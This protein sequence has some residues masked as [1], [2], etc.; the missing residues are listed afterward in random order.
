[1]PLYTPEQRERA[2]RNINLPPNKYFDEFGFIRDTQPNVDNTALATAKTSDTMSPLETFIGSGL[3]SVLPS[4]GG[5]GA[6]MATGAAG[7]SVWP[8]LGTFLGALGGAILGGGAISYGQDKLANY[9]A[10]ETMKRLR[11]GQAENPYAAGIGAFA[12]SLPTF[13]PTLKP[14]QFL[15][16]TAK[17]KIMSMGHKVDTG[18]VVEAL[19]DVGLGAGVEAGMSVATDI[20]QDR[21]VSLPRA[22]L[23][24][25]LGAVVSQP[26]KLAT[27]LTGAT[28]FEAPLD[29]AEYIRSGLG[30]GPAPAR[31]KLLQAPT[32]DSLSVAGEASR[33]QP[34]SE[35]KTAHGDKGLTTAYVN[36]INDFLESYRN[37]HLSTIDLQGES[38]G[39]YTPGTREMYA[40]PKYANFQTP[41]HE[42]MHMMLDDLVTS[43]AK[44]DRK[45]V[46]LLFKTVEDSKEFNEWSN[47]PFLKDGRTPSDYYKGKNYDGRSALVE[48]FIAERGGWNVAMEILKTANKKSWF[49]VVKHLKKKWTTG[50]DSEDYNWALAQRFLYDRAYPTDKLFTTLPKGRQQPLDDEDDWSESNYENFG[51][52]QQLARE[53]A[54]KEKAAKEAGQAAGRQVQEVQGGTTQ[55]QKTAKVAPLGAGSK[56]I[57]DSPLYREMAAKVKRRADGEEL[58]RLRTQLTEGEGAKRLRAISYVRP[59]DLADLKMAASKVR[60]KS[61][62][63]EELMAV[64]I[65]EPDTEKLRTLI[66]NVL[67]DIIMDARGTK[68]RAARAKKVVDTFYG[69]GVFDA[70]EGSSRVHRGESLA[71]PLEE[72][73]NLFSSDSQVRAKEI[74][75]IFDKELNDTNSFIPS[76]R[77][78]IYAASK[79]T[80]NKV[81]ELLNNKYEGSDEFLYRLHRGLFDSVKLIKELTNDSFFLEA[82][83]L[84][85]LFNQLAMS[86]RFTP[87]ELLSM[88]KKANA[89]SEK[90]YGP[91]ISAFPN[92]IPFEARFRE[93]P[94]NLV[95]LNADIIWRITK[96]EKP[97]DI[98]IDRIMFEAE[99]TT[100][101]TAKYKELYLRYSNSSPKKAIDDLSVAIPYL[102][103]E[104]FHAAVSKYQWP[105]TANSIH[106]A[107]TLTKEQLD[108]PFIFGGPN[109]TRIEV[110]LHK[111]A[112]EMSLEQWSELGTETKFPS[113]KEL[114]EVAKK[115]Y[116]DSLTRDTNPFPP[117]PKITNLTRGIRQIR[118]AFDVKEMK[119]KYNNCIVG[120]IPKALKGDTFL[121]ET[122]SAVAEIR[123]DGGLVQHLGD[124]NRAPSD[125]DKEAMLRFAEANPDL[126][127]A[128]TAW[129]IT[130]RDYEDTILGERARNKGIRPEQPI[131]NQQ[132]TREVRE[133]L[134]EEEANAY[135]A[136][137]NEARLRD[138]DEISLRNIAEIESDLADRLVIAAATEQDP[139]FALRQS[140]GGG[141]AVFQKDDNKTIEARRWKRREQPVEDRQFFTTELERELRKNPK[142]PFG[143]QLRKDGTIRADQLASVLRMKLPR[144]EQE[145][146][147]DMFKWL[148]DKG[149]ELVDPLIL[150]AKD[151][152][153]MEHS[154][155][156]DITTDTIDSS[157]LNK[158]KGIFDRVTSN[159]QQFQHLMDNEGLSVRVST[160]HEGFPFAIYGGSVNVRPGFA[161][162]PLFAG[163]HGPRNIN[164]IDEWKVTFKSDPSEMLDEKQIDL[165]EA[166]IKNKQG[167]VDLMSMFDDDA[168]GLQTRDNVRWDNI[169]PRKVDTLPDYTELSVQHNQPGE[170]LQGDTIDTHYFPTNTMTHVRGYMHTDEGTGEKTFVI[171]EAQSDWDASIRDTNERRKRELPDLEHDL[172][173]YEGILRDLESIVEV[174]PSLEHSDSYAGFDKYG[175]EIVAFRASKESVQ[176]KIAYK[177]RI[178]KSDVANQKIAVDNAREG[179]NKPFLE[180]WQA[181]A[182]K[183]AIRHAVKEGADRI[184]IT[185]APTSMITQ[186]HI[187]YP[188]TKKF[189]SQKL[190]ESY[191]NDPYR[192]G[193]KL[194]VYQDF[195]TKDWYVRSEP[196]R[197]SSAKVGRAYKFRVERE[198]G[199]RV[200]YE[201]KLPSI[202]KKLVGD[203]G[204]LR[205]YGDTDAI[206]EDAI[207]LAKLGAEDFSLRARSYKLSDEVKSK[208]LNEQ[209]QMFSDRFQPLDTTLPEPTAK[210]WKI[211][212]DSFLES[213][214]KKVSKLG[215]SGSY[216]ADKMNRYYAK[217]GFYEGD[218]AN[219][220]AMFFDGYVPP[221]GSEDK[222]VRFLHDIRHKGKSKVNLTD[223][224]AH[225]VM[226]WKE[227]LK[228][229][230]DKH[231]AIGMLIKEGP[232]AFREMVQD[233]NYSPDM[234]DPEVVYY[235]T[236]NRASSD[237]RAR[238]LK[239]DFIDWALQ[240]SD[241]NDKEALEYYN[242]YMD[243]VSGVRDLA[244]NNDRAYFG[245]LRRAKSIGLPY[246][247]VEKNPIRL[248][249]RYGRRTAHDFAFFEELQNDPTARWVSGLV[250]QEGNRPSELPI[251]SIAENPEVQS[252]MQG[253]ILGDSPYRGAD[254]LT[255]ARIASAA[256]VVS[257]VIMGAGTGA[258]DIFTLPGTMAPYLQNFGDLKAVLKGARRTFKVREKALR[259]G[260]TQLDYDAFQFGDLEYAAPDRIVRNLSKASKFF[261]KYQGR[262]LLENV[263]RQLTYAIGEEIAATKIAQAKA[264]DKKA[265]KWLETFTKS[266]DDLTA[267]DTVSRIAKEFT[268]RVQ[269]AYDARNLPGIAL[270]GEIAPFLN[271]ARWSIEKYNVVK[272]DVFKPM[273]E[274]DFKPLLM[275]TLGSM[276]SA[277]AIEKLNELLSNKRGHDATLKEVWKSPDASLD[278]YIYK[279]IALGQLGAFAG[280]A[281]DATK[282]ATAT[283]TGRTSYNNPLSFPLYTFV[284]ETL[285]D[286][287]SDATEAIKEGEDPVNTLLNMTHAIAKGSLQNYRYVSSW[288]DH[289]E[290]KRKEKFRDLAVWKQL[291][292]ETDAMKEVRV[293]RFLKQ[294][295]RKFKQSDDLG[296]S[297][298]MLEGLI[299][300]AFERAKG[301]PFK[302]KQELAGLKANS[303]QTMPSPK[304]MP[305]S[306]AKY[307][308]HLRETQGEEAAN[309][310][311]QDWM[312]Q[313]AKNRVKSGMVP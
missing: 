125:M 218:F 288:Y 191:A 9:I 153:K 193:Q 311:L 53:R 156:R 296:E 312:L 222:I 144:A 24:G 19:A 179:I 211:A 67:P 112:S 257:N 6:G 304:T 91:S 271:L 48:E 192:K 298:S 210:G 154:L 134:G 166:Y 111:A 132:F 297:T 89:L 189:S 212:P 100:D 97:F 169:L 149:Q 79:R 116:Q 194:D 246:S 148:E 252:A 117:N 20:A 36:K 282:L 7:G 93:V 184:A 10:P 34:I 107:K 242:N 128:D 270:E 150:T 127:L 18:K 185:D 221:K 119:R 262:Q 204:E 275:Y 283:V 206:G 167:Q 49:D 72:N 182:L 186:G 99:D 215:E 187:G 173:I 164:N 236:H 70:L 162:A 293:N 292:D 143:L 142:R 305:N 260:S 31:T 82:P 289:K 286:N 1:M 158:E 231:K 254:Q 203:K 209:T 52:K 58:L 140:V 261:R 290:T 13:R 301:D 61:L 313:N 161:R 73:D 213:R 23:M 108:K 228:E 277:V 285:A 68:A 181:T 287:L 113:I 276:L 25:T 129:H 256:R 26:T 22:A 237:P 207:T 195:T 180:N 294:D 133:K 202:M 83:T 54:A 268:D 138:Y 131:E 273:T 74:K 90:E 199:H 177:L 244:G 265:K 229:I 303:Y 223:Q 60:H 122:A 109:N 165:I 5:L 171:L 175:N 37:A 225:I 163:I 69:K 12:G 55:A 235:M 308:L 110:P 102:F 56:S 243:A 75:R 197:E 183:A 123:P 101:T 146:L 65:W 2:A 310:R 64:P 62:A 284:T 280:I 33:G 259:S 198:M 41:L 230:G 174:K 124:W 157:L 295:E 115:A 17:R 8:G 51:L 249:Y 178:A 205:T 118:N 135:H 39:A 87:Y 44:V 188:L 94:P 103:E 300:K 27:K 306:F 216:L 43:D 302:F 176:N 201:T 239:D 233:P 106:L 196:T 46:D 45:L 227:H 126:Y 3:E 159:L 121:Y 145:V 38:R 80:L 47:S 279:I 267:P 190:A 291:N 86:G 28:P 136:A 274:G 57:Q 59:R 266:V 168:Q 245:A 77:D 78:S 130:R 264:G 105:Y 141:K 35:L 220:A 160:T 29:S 219:T 151:D 98:V 50:L 307:L 137:F 172:K 85:Q 250:D 30:V 114:R 281:S 200:N 309:A 15:S 120:F 139:F 104:H 214:V 232:K 240:K 272:E 4:L 269:G 217:R 251:D 96:G 81:S 248:F 170:R 16:E 208:F 76:D 42:G 88:Q 278:D 238:K 66:G 255:H 40:D 147:G 253:I 241:M 11:E 32:E 224:E 258:R 152:W 155:S 247:W 14:L 63:I 21:E 92:Y 263:S 95:R 84:V 299:T 71:Q 234:V 226:L